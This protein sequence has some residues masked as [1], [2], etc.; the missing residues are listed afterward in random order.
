ML[1][2]PDNRRQDLRENKIKKKE[3]KKEKSFSK[4][5]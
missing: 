4:Y 1:K 3:R 5:N 2:P